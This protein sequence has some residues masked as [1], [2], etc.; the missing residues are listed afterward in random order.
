MSL[1]KLGEFTSHS[2]LQL[3]YKIDC[4]ALTDEDVECCAKLISQVYT[5]TDVHGIDT[6]GTRLAR[7]L[8]KYCTT[9]EKHT[10]LIVD[11]VMTTGFSITKAY[12]TF[13]NVYQE[14][15]AAVIFTRNGT[16]NKGILPLPVYALFVGD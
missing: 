12:D 1:F 7:A 2:G 10:L 4:D 14:I 6:G 15:H 5:F 3:S 8:V 9:N 11:D 13:K 16:I